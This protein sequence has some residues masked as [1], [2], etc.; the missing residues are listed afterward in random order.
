MTDRNYSSRDGAPKAK[1][2]RKRGGG[3]LDAVHKLG[4]GGKTGGEVCPCAIYARHV[5][6]PHLDGINL[7]A[8]RLEPTEPTRRQV[9]SRPAKERERALAELYACKD[10][11]EL[12]R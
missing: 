12:F 2:V 7:H 8:P 1:V 10:K 9:V 4:G 5:A 11:S 6:P 3:L